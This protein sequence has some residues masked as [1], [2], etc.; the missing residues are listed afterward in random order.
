MTTILS[1]LGHSETYNYS[2]ELETALAKA[3]RE[4]STHLTPQII[5]GEQNIVIHSEWDNLNKITNIHGSN[6]VN[7]AG[8]IMMQVVKEGPINKSQRALP[9]F[10]RSKQVRAFK[11]DPPESLPELSFKRI[12]L[13]GS[14][15]NRTQK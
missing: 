7:S 13:L 14:R 6:I 2:L 11:V 9:S 12:E 4:C 10:G 3:L 15:Y 8:G 5:T 1:R